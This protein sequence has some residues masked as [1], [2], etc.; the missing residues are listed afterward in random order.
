MIHDRYAFWSVRY[1]VRLSIA[2]M[3]FSCFGILSAGASDRIVKVGLYEN[4][5]K[6]FTAESGK[7]AGIFI[8]IIEHI[9]KIE[10]WDLRYVPGTFG[11]GLDRL[12]KGEIDL[13]PDVAYSADR[14]AVYS[15][16][17][18]PV[19]TSWFQVF[20]PTGNAIRSIADLNGKRILVLDRSV[21][22]TAF[23]R[24]S[25]AFGVRSDVITMPDYKTMF[26]AVAKG[27]AD[28][29]VTNTYYGIRHAKKYGLE[30]T[31][32]VFEP[33]E[34]FFAAPENAPRQVLDRIDSHLSAL[35]KDPQSVYYASLKRWTSE[36]VRFTVPAWMQI[37][38]L[39]AGLALVMSLAGGVVLK[40][41]VNARTLELQTSERR[42]RQ[43]FASNPAPM[44]IYQRGTL[45]MLAVNNAFV[46]HYGYS[47]EEALSLHLPDL[48]HEEEKGTVVKLAAGLK[49]HEC[50]GEWHHLKADGSIITI[51]ARS[52]NIDYWGSDARIAVIADITDRKRVE[53]A[54]RHSEEKFFKAFHATPDAI[55]IS[56]AFDGL[57]IEVN[58]VF[59][60]KTGYSREDALSNSTVGLNVWA[61]PH[62]REHYIA[63]IREQGNVRDLEA[64]FRTKTG[65]VLDGLVSGEPI[66]LGDNFCLLT[67]I[68]DITERKK[69]EEQIR[70][71]NDDLRRHADVLEQRVAERTAELA[72]AMEKA[73]AADR[74][75]SAFLAT[76]SHELRTPLNS[77]IGFTGIL[78]Q[79]LA[80]TL[81]TEQHKQLTMVQSSARHLLALI[82]DVLDISKI[83]AGELH[84]SPAPFDLRQSVEKMVK[85][86]SPLAHKKGIALRLDIADA[87]GTITTDQRRLEQVM[88]NLLNNAVKFT[89]KGHVRISCRT[90]N[91]HYLL[92]F[93]DTGVGM[94][95]EDIPNIFQPF[96]QI[97]S[98]LTRKHEGTG[99][100]LSICKKIIDIM[101]GTI[102][103]E[104]QLGAGSTFT[105]RLP[106]QSG[107][108]S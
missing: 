53:E 59:L 13:M 16:H 79:G 2:L 36:E 101:D 34:L 93:S 27:E 62:D 49:G 83:E 5:P 22:H 24:L 32:V 95:P 12:L 67:I 68:R 51:V 25:T 92:S 48:C 98:G 66:V 88:L 29:A 100:G 20:A 77:I 107:G 57:L 14:E 87:V 50:A 18:V 80:G 7:P 69:A 81:N 78:L 39:M 47:A 31:A 64:Q 54:L 82:N 3:A 72:V 9:A 85:T 104:S 75:K 76:M 23:I 73:Q 35:K 11:E 97:D 74:I 17:K 86:V 91:D 38:G 102:S 105:V 106:G 56:R 65:A 45:Q 19:L 42:Y 70:R 30:D 28:A 37:I 89:E 10:G 40:H 26:E 96:R 6:I 108:Q 8:E 4:A 94:Q 90:E 15:F 46:S 60:R 63:G 1:L 58:D 55:V 99:L 103:V 71:L 61:D 33:S 44:F 41:Q 84:L 43:L 52:E 21:Q